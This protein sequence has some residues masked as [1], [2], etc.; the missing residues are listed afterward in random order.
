MSSGAIRIRANGGSDV[1]V[2]D[3]TTKDGPLILTSLATSSD[4]Y[5]VVGEGGEETSLRDYLDTQ[6]TIYGELI[7]LSLF[8]NSGV[9]ST[10]VA[11]D[12]PEALGRVLDGDER[13]YV[14]APDKVINGIIHYKNPPFDHAWLDAQGIRYETPE[15]R[16]VDLGTDIGPDWE[17]ADISA[18]AITGRRPNGNRSTQSRGVQQAASPAPPTQGGGTTTTLS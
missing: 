14:V 2:V 1:F 12:D 3:P 10:R 18:S 7:A 6:G 8:P 11:L 15:A 4:E 16:A 9:V 5:V 17:G 13:F